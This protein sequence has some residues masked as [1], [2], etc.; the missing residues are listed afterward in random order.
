MNPTTDILF[1]ITWILLFA[2]AIRSIAKGWS[3]SSEDTARPNGMWTT[4]VKKAVHPEMEGVK[5]GEELMGVTFDQ[6]TSCSLEEYQ[7]LQKRIEEL[8]IELA[9]EEDEDDDEDDDGD[10][11]VRV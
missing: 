11:I 5:P 9:M 4:Q 3:I 8:K 6:K 1:S 7:S 2:F 10:I